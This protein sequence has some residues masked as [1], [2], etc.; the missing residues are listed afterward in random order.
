[1]CWLPASVLLLFLIIQQVYAVETIRIITN[2]YQTADNVESL[3]AAFNNEYEGQYSA[4]LTR[5]NNGA[6]YVTELKSILMN[7]ENLY[8]VMYFSMNSMVDLLLAGVDSDDSRE[9]WNFKAIDDYVGS[10]TTINWED[11]NFF[12]RYYGTR[13]AMETFFVPF[14][15]DYHF[16]HYRSDVLSKYGISPP[17]TLSDVLTVSQTLHASAMAATDG[18]PDFPICLVCSGDEYSGPFMIDFIAPFTQYEGTTQGA[19]FDSGDLDSL[20]SSEG[21]KEAI[22]LFKEVYQYSWPA[23]VGDSSGIGDL[24]NQRAAYLNGSCAMIVDWA[25][26][27]FLPLSDGT[28]AVAANTAHSLMP[29]STRVFNRAAG[30]VETCTA[31]LCPYATAA[32][33]GDLINT[34]PYAANGG[35]GMAIPAMSDRSDAAW[36]FIEFANTPSRINP[37]TLNGKGWEPFRSSV[38][39]ESALS[40]WEA[41]G[42]TEAQFDS[43]V[44]AL[45]AFMAHGNVALEPRIPGL[46]EYLAAMATYLGPYVTNATDDV[47]QALSDLDTAIEAIT[48]SY[49]RSDQLKY[50]RM[51]LNIDPLTLEEL[52]ILFIV[53]GIIVMTLALLLTCTMMPIT[54]FFGFIKN[55]G[56][57]RLASPSFLL[58]VNVGCLVLGV[59]ELVHVATFRYPGFLIC[60]VRHLLFLLGFCT[61]LGAL[62][63]KQFRLAFILIMTGRAKR[64]GRKFKVMTDLQLVPVF[65]TFMP[66]PFLI[67]L[68]RVLLDPLRA[69]YVTLTTYTEC[70]VCRSV[71]NESWFVVAIVT[72]VLYLL[73]N[74]VLV[75]ITR[76]LPISENKV[77]ALSIEI[78][79]V[80]MVV[81]G[82]VELITDDPLIP[83]AY[84]PTILAAG[85]I[86]LQL[87]TFA[88]KLWKV[89]RRQPLSKRDFRILV[90]EGMDVASGYVMCPCG[91][92][93]AFTVAGNRIQKSEYDHYTDSAASTSSRGRARSIRS[94]L[95]SAMRSED[96]HPAAKACYPSMGMDAVFPLF[97]ADG[98]VVDPE[99]VDMSSFITKDMV[100]RLMATRHS[101]EDGLEEYDIEVLED[102]HSSGAQC[103]A[104]DSSGHAYSSSDGQA[105]PDGRVTGVLRTETAEQSLPEA[106]FMEAP[107]DDSVVTV[108]DDNV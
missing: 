62:F 76:K 10:S 20:L 8:D 45:S 85:I 35:W 73:P 60:T 11:I 84:T 57:F 88:P 97:D 40:L 1:M 19:F 28:A 30:H 81:Y 59:S 94:V 78:I 79:A 26:M 55:D 18:D 49:G 108:G 38:I 37:Y 87:V 27:F 51:N 32:S 31:D 41:A 69:E 92:G 50:Y 86:L 101:T 24:L 42:F 36:A 68:A 80:I 99:T 25:D 70:Q 107:D 83:P 98:N 82:L 48:D 15:G 5:S 47:D 77:L 46:T 104:N 52:D 53:L 12:S 64:T 74:A 54:V 91:C 100:D 65:L 63:T 16:L 106:G 22:Q 39:D 67:V 75:F 89:L 66:L 9:K 103:F 102:G 29:G 4:T 14:D 58:V 17:E 43:T 90:G 71:Y 95:S 61:I 33:S 3:V 21:G 105:T 93:H 44:S 56:N 7:N 2:N 72:G 96:H 6:E 23:V 34:A 13:F